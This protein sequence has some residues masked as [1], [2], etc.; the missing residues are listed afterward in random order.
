MSD[1]SRKY[2]L[3]CLRIA[4]DCIVLSR[5]AVNPELQQ[6]FHQMGE[7]W[8]SKAESGPD[9]IET[10]RVTNVTHALIS[11]LQITGDVR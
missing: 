9:N 6:H 7:E 11:R 3:E 4:A 1:D 8:T 2:E 5:M 10:S